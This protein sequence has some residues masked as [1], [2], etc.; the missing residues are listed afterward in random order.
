MVVVVSIKGFIGMGLLDGKAAFVTGGGS[1]IGAATC[2]RF[3]AEG[4]RVAVVDVNG[5]A[6]KAVAA[7]RYRVG[8]RRVELSE[9]RDGDAIRVYWGEA[10]D[11]EA[12]RTRDL[13]F[14]LALQGQL[15][16]TALE[17]NVDFR[18]VEGGA[19]EYLVP[20]GSGFLVVRADADGTFEVRSR[21]ARFACTEQFECDVEA[22]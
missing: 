12:L 2:R 8:E 19:L 18:L 10:I 17:L 11:R 4:A 3:A 21:E 16:E 20:V 7:C 13:V 5:D 6:A 9:G 1:G 15:D 14:S 22:P